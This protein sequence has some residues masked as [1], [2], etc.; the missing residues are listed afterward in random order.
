MTPNYE[1]KIDDLHNAIVGNP[2]MGHHGLVSR[3]RDVEDYQQKDKEFKHKVAG[4]LAV[5][6]PIL[7]AFWHWL[8]K[9]I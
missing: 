6:T 7:V 5:G 1:K 2:E 4:G 8:L 9:H 3:V